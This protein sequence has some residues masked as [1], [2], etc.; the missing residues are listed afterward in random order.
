M[1]LKNKTI[2]K[3][4]STFTFASLI[5]YSCNKTKTQCSEKLFGH[6]KKDTAPVEKE[7]STAGKQVSDFVS[8]QY[9]IQYETDGDLNQDGL[10]DKALVLRKKKTTL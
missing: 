6:Y 2:E 7:Q 3:I 5:A 4:I 10:P 8:S 9:E 1:Y